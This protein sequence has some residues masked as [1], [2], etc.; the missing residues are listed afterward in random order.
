MHRLP[1]RISMAQFGGVRIPPKL[2][3]PSCYISDAFPKS[4]DMG[5]GIPD[6]YG[7]PYIGSCGFDEKCGYFTYP[8]SSRGI[9]TS[10][11]GVSGIPP[12]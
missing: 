5:T 8:D 1:I 12:P 7:N 3:E 6:T 2:S 4:F 11:R 9:R 10:A